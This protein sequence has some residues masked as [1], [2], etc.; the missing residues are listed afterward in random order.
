MEAVKMAYDKI[1]WHYP[2]GNIIHS[3]SLK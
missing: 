1:T 2:G 3:D